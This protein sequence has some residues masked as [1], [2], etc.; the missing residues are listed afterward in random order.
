MKYIIIEALGTL[1]VAAIIAPIAYAVI[2]N[3]FDKN[4]DDI[5]GGGLHP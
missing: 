4:D 5:Y 3:L 2:V 1:V